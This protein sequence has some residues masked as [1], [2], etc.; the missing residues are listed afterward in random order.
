V[1]RDPIGRSARKKEEPELESTAI[2]VNA[3]KSLTK[4][5]KGKSEFPEYEL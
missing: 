2:Y 1:G 5:E 3:L 4:E